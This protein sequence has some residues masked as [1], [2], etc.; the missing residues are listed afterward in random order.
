[1]GGRQPFPVPRNAYEQSLA[2]PGYK[3][4]VARSQTAS[5]LRADPNA[6]F[7]MDQL[8]RLDKVMLVVSVLGLVINVVQI[9]AISNHAW[10]R[11]TAMA[12][13]QPFHSYLSLGSVTFGNATHP[14]KD[15]RYFCS[16]SEDEC[17]LRTLCTRDAPK[18][19]K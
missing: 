19:C 4:P 17:S 16:A 10:L 12:D 5:P 7:S 6:E 2:P 18:T 15:N 1:M 8:D 14:A 11:A 3:A 13:G 9:N